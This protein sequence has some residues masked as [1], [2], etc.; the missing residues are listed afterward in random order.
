MN[1]VKSVSFSLVMLLSFSA[2]ADHHKG[3]REEVEQARQDAAKSSILGRLLGAAVI[4]GIGIAIGKSNNE[5]LN[6]TGLGVG[7]SASGILGALSFLFDNE[8]SRT[9]R[10]MA[11]TAPVVA[12]LGAGISSDKVSGQD[13]ILSKAPLGLGELAKN[14]KNTESKHAF[15]ALALVTAYNAAKPWLNGMFEWGSGKVAHVHKRFT[16]R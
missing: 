14:V 13:G 12:M 6:N 16:N 8:N 3:H 4:G 2:Y 1:F 5:F 7:L 9:L 10:G 11:V 15:Q